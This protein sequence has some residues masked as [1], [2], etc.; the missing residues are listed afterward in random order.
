MK[1][2]TEIVWQFDDQGNM[3]KVSEKAFEYDGPVAMCSGGGGQ[4]TQSNKPPKALQPIISG[5][6]TGA[7]DWFNNY[8]P[9]FYPGSTVA[10]FSSETEQALNMQAQ[11]AM[12]G[13]PLNA[14]AQSQVNQTLTGEAFNQPGFDAALRSGINRVMPGVNSVFSRSGRSGSGLH[15]AAIAESLGNVYGGLWDSERNR[16]MQASQMAPSLAMA[17]YNDPAQLRAVGMERENLANQQIQE[18]IARHQFEQNKGYE[19]L[20]KYAG[21]ANMLMGGGYGTTST[22]YST[23]PAAGAL[24]GAATGAGIY[25]MMGGP[26]GAAMM[27]NPWAWAALG[28]G[29][30]LGGLR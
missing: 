26:M 13:N 3:H 22:P 12:A 29:A 15:D 19:G 17:D 14:N 20:Q 18:Q 6:A 4:T 5:V 21:I 24:G 9:S 27:S 28:G 10:P 2:Y 7:Q 8:N 16:Q 1:I 25:S 23:N 11:R 30:L